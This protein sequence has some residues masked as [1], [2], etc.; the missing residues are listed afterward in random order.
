VG[1]I[2][3]FITASVDSERL[4]RKYFLRLGDYSVIEHIVRRAEH[5]GFTP[6]LCVPHT[7][8]GEFTAHTQ[9]KNIMGGD[10]ENREAR[11]FEASLK[12]DITHFHNIDGDDPFFDPY[13]VIESFNAGYRLSR[14][15]PSY[16]SESGTGRVG[17]TYNL[18]AQSS[19]T[20]R[21][22]DMR[23]DYPWPQRLTL[24]YP[25]DYHL[26]VAVNRIV[27]GYMAPRKVI[28]DV[29]IRNPDLHKINWHRNA[30]WKARQ[31][32]ERRS[33]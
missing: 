1:G 28:D 33:G 18:R 8:I 3:A 22:H 26:L 13:A 10:P 23:E 17:T 14:V 27:G 15:F 19:E 6:Y 12:W 5:F 20:R 9:C 31:L 30:E 11:L 16:N 2:A 29:F 24:D 21:L 4:P 25:E 7:D 32:N